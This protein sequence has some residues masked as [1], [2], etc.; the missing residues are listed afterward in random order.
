MV[1]YELAK[2]FETCHYTTRI[3]LPKMDPVKGIQLKE[4]S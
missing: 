2:H 4:S 1:N 3:Q